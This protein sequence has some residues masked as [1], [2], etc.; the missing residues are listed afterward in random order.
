M[1]RLNQLLASSALFA[2]LAVPALAQEPSQEPEGYKFTTIKETKISPIQDQANT[3]TCWSFSGIGFLEAEAYRLTGKEV[4]LAPM[5]IVSQSYK[6]KARDFVRYHGFLNFAQGGAFGD[7]L[8]VLGSHGVVP[9]EEMIG[10]NYGAKRHTHT[11]MEAIAKGFVDAL[12]KEMDKAGH[13]SSAWEE[14]FDGIIDAYLGKAPQSFTYEGK[15]YTPATFAQALKLDPN[16]YVSLT[17]FS[18]HPFYSQF[19]LEIPDNWRHGLSYNLPIEELIEVIDNAVDNGYTVAWGSDVSEAGFTRNG[20]A[21][22][23]DVEAANSDHGSDQARWIGSSGNN[24]RVSIGQLIRTP[25]S[26]EI[27]VTQEYRQK[28]F[29]DLSTTDD[30]GM[31]IYGLANDQTGK[32]FYMVK[33]SWGED[34]GKYNGIWYAS[35]A[36]VAGK[37]MNIVVHK[38]AIPRAIRTKLGI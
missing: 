11:E 19:V 9:M 32:P 4:I 7:V 37:T 29:D 38:D 3:G 13:L 15:S 24:N 34:A 35:K 18:H 22:L 6:D 21:V 8:H 25:G 27:K 5:Y 12:V 36:F 10:L 1:K 26:P 16:N 31:L 23:V 20:L 30:H 2:F 33:N 17:S 28:G 14:A